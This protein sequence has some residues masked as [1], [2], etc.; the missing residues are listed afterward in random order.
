MIKNDDIAVR[1]V[2]S[3]YTV[4]AIEVWYCYWYYVSKGAPKV[5]DKLGN[6]L[7]W[8]CEKRVKS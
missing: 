7:T 1:I 4:F 6:S 5:F 2:V 3:Y 8:L